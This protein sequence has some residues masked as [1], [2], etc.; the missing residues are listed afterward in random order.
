MSN[1]V[2]SLI[3]EAT[4]A[5]QGGAMEAD[6]ISINGASSKRQMGRIKF[7]FRQ[8]SSI[9]GKVMAM[10]TFYTMCAASIVNA[11]MEPK[12]R[13]QNSDLAIIDVRSQN[14]ALVIVDGK[15]GVDINSISSEN[16]ASFKVLK[17]QAAI[18]KYGEK[19]KNGVVIITTKPNHP[20]FVSDRNAGNN[21]DQIIGVW[22]SVSPPLTVEGEEKI[23]IITKDRFIWTHAIDGVIA[24]SLGGSYSFDGENYIENIKFGTGNQRSAFGRKVI[25]K[26]RFEGEKMYIIGGYEN[27]SRVFNEIWERVE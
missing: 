14:S 10:I 13:S 6:T 9:C 4:V 23:K 3:N 19:G 16:I 12:I 21:T 18:E 7:S 17:D 11:Q 8:M 2:S 5:N 27:D 24:Y 1:L 20:L 15:E 26:V 22:K 25:Y